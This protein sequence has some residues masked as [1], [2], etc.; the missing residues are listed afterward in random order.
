MLS[1]QRAVSTA[2]V[3]L[4]LR[5][6]SHGTSSRLTANQFANMAFV[7]LAHGV[8]RAKG[9][10]SRRPATSPLQQSL[11]LKRAQV[12]L[13]RNSTLVHG[14]HF[15]HSDFKTQDAWRNLRSETEK[16]RTYSS[17]EG[18]VILSQPGHREV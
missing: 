6:A 7:C 13:R 8:S 17:F 15:S 1:L 10:F 12:C 5:L 2:G 18:R 9:W 3:Q 14:P 16:P 11:P 4:L